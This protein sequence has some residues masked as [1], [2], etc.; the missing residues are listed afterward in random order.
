MRGWLILL[1][2]L[3]LWA[4]HFFL[5]YGIG[6]FW[7]EGIAPRI[8]VAILTLAALGIAAAIFLRLWRAAPVDGHERWR[9]QSTLGGLLL[10]GVAILWQAL[11]ALLSQ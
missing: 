11:P 2:G 10:G 8:A 7:G 1:S 5:L 3:V 9:R 4:G 6:E